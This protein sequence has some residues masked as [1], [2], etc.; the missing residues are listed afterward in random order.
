MGTWHL[1]RSSPP[2]GRDCENPEMEQNKPQ[3]WL[4]LH[5]GAAGGIIVLIPSKWNVGITGKCE[6]NITDLVCLRIDESVI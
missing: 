4:V 1:P 3:H 2:Y 5:E 6:E